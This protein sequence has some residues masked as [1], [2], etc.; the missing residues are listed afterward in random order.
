[1]TETNPLHH[2]QEAYNTTMT[3]TF[4]SLNLL[5]R[6]DVLHREIAEEALQKIFAIVDEG[7]HSENPV[8]MINS[9]ADVL[10]EVKREVDGF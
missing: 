2:N 4:H 9:L 10:R 8:N 7:R 5:N 3:D 1:M 6:N